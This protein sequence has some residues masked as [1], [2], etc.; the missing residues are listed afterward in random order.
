M[1][2]V[3]M[4]MDWICLFESLFIFLFFKAWLDLLLNSAIFTALIIHKGSPWARKKIIKLDVYSI[5]KPGFPS[6][7]SLQKTLERFFSCAVAYACEY[8]WELPGH[9]KSNKAHSAI[10]Q[11]VLKSH[12]TFVRYCWQYR[13]LL[14]RRNGN[15]WIDVDIKVYRLMYILRIVCVSQLN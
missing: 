11:T 9:I 5:L 8:A 12:K 6:T 10:S 4:L 7:V 1:V 3:C 13:K 14:Y 15:M 2:A